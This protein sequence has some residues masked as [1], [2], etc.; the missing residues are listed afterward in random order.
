MDVR[1]C[2][3]CHDPLHGMSTS[4]MALVSVHA[5]SVV[6]RS[7]VCVLGG[8]FSL[9]GARFSDFLLLGKVLLRFRL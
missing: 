8:V 3:H 6:T 5:I 4:R 1:F 9:F 7:P 2:L